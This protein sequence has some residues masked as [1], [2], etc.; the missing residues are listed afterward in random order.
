VYFTFVQ[1]EYRTF[2]QHVNKKIKNFKNI[3]SREVSVTFSRANYRL[4]KAIIA[5]KLPDTGAKMTFVSVKFRPF[6]PQ[7]LGLPFEIEAAACPSR[8]NLV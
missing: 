3:F 7:F 8:G 1:L 2:V 6:V 4:F 5:E